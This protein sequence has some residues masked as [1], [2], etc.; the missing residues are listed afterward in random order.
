M[1]LGEHVERVLTD[2]AAVHPRITMPREPLRRLIAKR[3]QD[4]EGRKAIDCDELYL[5][6]A[7]VLGDSAAIATFE[8]RYF[9]AIPDALSRL[10]LSADE[11]ADVE[12][13]LRQRLFVGT[14]RRRSVTLHSGPS[15]RSIDPIDAAAESGEPSEVPRVVAYAGQGQLAS[16]VR[17]AA[18]RAALNL[19]RDR[20]RM[21][22]DSTDGFDDVPVRAGDAELATLKS[23][24]RSEFKSCFEQALA[25]LDPQERSLL[26]LAVVRGLGIERIGTIYGIHRATAARWITTARSNLTRTVHTILTERLGV[27]SERSIGELLPLVEAQLELS[28]ERLLRTRAETSADPA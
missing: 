17:V 11:I 26:G 18:V 20:G 28:L 22:A 9:A 15:M 24:L 16:L 3:L 25:K 13:I 21:P 6:A 27:S 4:E 2:G 5:A 19:L 12:A 14:G 7:C 10:S 1:P 8:E 23:R